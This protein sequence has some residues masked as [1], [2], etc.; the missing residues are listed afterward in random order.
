MKEILE[1]QREHIKRQVKEHEKDDPNQ[2]KLDFGEAA[3]ELRQLNANKRYWGTR[4]DMLREELKTEPDR[5]RDVYEVKATRVE[6]VGLVYLWP[7]TG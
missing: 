5:I 1:T 2:L 3:D 4:L 7:V 6:P